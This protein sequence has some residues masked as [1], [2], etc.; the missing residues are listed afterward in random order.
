MSLPWACRVVVLFLLLAVAGPAVA[1]EPPAEV[2]QIPWQ[3]LRYEAQKLFF[4]GH[5]EVRLDRLPGR[6]AELDLPGPPGS[7]VR[8]DIDSELAGRRSTI[9][10]WLEPDRG[11]TFARIKRR[12]GSKAYEKTWLL[13]DGGLRTD[14][15][16]PA[17]SQEVRQPPSAWSEQERGF[18]HLPNSIPCPRLTTPSAL[19]YLLATHP[20]A[21]GEEL[22]FCSASN[23]GIHQTTVRAEGF[24]KLGVRYQER[25]GDR[26]DAIEKEI[27]ALRL[28]VRSEGD[29]EIDF[30]GL[31]GE[32]ELFL[33]PQKRLLL[34]VRGDVPLLGEVQVRLREATLRAP[35]DGP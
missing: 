34:E 3:G 1:Q 35:H 19:F 15:R 26:L 12:M 11:N 6:E 9:R 29:N 2:T 10:L 22:P 33:H 14:R 20:L 21:P 27:Q 31:E 28:T 32:I 24:E 17:N 8:L 18:L 30:L 25:S 4:S 16:A 13:A 23:Q 5:T 7:K